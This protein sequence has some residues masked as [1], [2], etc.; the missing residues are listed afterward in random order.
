[1]TDS[2]K[3]RLE[4]LADRG[5][6]RGA[7]DVL[8]AARSQ[9]TR[10]RLG[11]LVAAAAAVVLAMGAVGIVALDDDGSPTA[12]VA[13]PPATT[14]PTPPVVAMSAS[15]LVLFDDCSALLG[16]LQERGRE[17]VG[18]YGLWG[19]GV[20]PQ[21][22]AFLEDFRRATAFTA[23][24]PAAPPAASGTNTQ[25]EGVDEPDLVETDGERLFVVRDG[26]LHVVDVETLSV[27][28]SLTLGLVHVTGAVLIDESLVVLANEPLTDGSGG[29]A[30][31]VVVDVSGSPEIRERMTA[32]GQL[33]DA[34]AADGRL[35]VVLR[36]SPTLAFTY[37]S[38][39]AWEADPAAEE[40]AT[41]A[42]RQR[43]AESTIDDWLPHWQV[44]NA[45][46]STSAP[47]RIVPCDEVRH[48]RTFAGFDQTTLMTL[49]LDDLAASAVT[50]VV[51]SSEVVYGSDHSI[52]VTTAGYQPRSA[53]PSSP[54]APLLPTPTD[55]H[56][57]ALGDAPT[58]A[59][60]GRVEGQVGGPF[61][62]SEFDG[63][64][65]VASTTF[66][67]Q[68]DSRV[69]VLV[70]RD[71]ELV[72]TGVVSGLGV[73]ETIRGVRFVGDLGYVVTFRQ[74]DPLYVID[75]RDPV[76]PRLA[77][78][79]EIPG[80]SAYLH[81]VGDGLLLGLG[82]D[83]DESGTL[84]GGAVSLFD[85][86]DPAVPTRPA[87][88]PFGPLTWPVV[89][90]DHHAFTWS[91]ES[92]AAYVPI[93]RL[94]PDGERGSIEVLRVDGT[95]LVPVG[96]IE[97]AGEGADPAALLDRAVL[98]GDRVFSISRQGVQVNDRASLAPIAWIPLP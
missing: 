24:E 15:S 62:L 79:L 14:S 67:G 52:Y 8:A 1:M 5:A 90:K 41:E 37:P 13:A 6:S 86:R 10:P 83:G 85:V 18:P 30:K 80:Y 59:A 43:I 31:V 60:S 28:S 16:D 94:G 88:H 25:E 47:T 23:R 77:G 35:H 89:E 4:E 21:R 58:Y 57:F 78:H 49:E 39:A 44:T 2:L 66:A 61:G 95:T 75:L 38:T 48:P 7:A 76:N 11:R 34:R 12:D 26:T 82:H 71:G 45:S 81:L 97:P 92:S 64:L 74:T 20:G 63:H 68:S 53:D 70:E 33:V 51:T 73:S 46:G 3:R 98:V 91:P 36:S 93:T 87:M 84:L 29:D 65:R 54:P 42:N 19:L 72:P 40:A 32:T 56:R 55:V 69:T 96:R 50:S 9:D 22:D 17:H 27:T